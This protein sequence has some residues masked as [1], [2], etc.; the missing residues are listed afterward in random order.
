MA[1]PYPNLWVPPPPPLRDTNASADGLNTV[2]YKTQEN[3]V[4]IM[5]HASYD[6]S[7]GANNFH[8]HSGK[9][10]F[11]ALK[12]A[13]FR[14]YVYYAPHFTVYTDCNSLSYVLST[15]WLNA[16]GVRWIAE[17]TDYR[18][19]FKYRSGRKIESQTY[20]ADTLYRLPL[21]AVK[22]IRTEETSMETVH[23]IMHDA[24]AAERCPLIVHI[25]SLKTQ[26]NAELQGKKFCTEFLPNRIS[27]VS[28]SRA[29]EEDPIKVRKCVMDR[30]KPQPTEI[31]CQL[32]E[33]KILFRECRKLE[34]GENKILV[35]KP[36]R[37]FFPNCFT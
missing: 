20:T 4:K 35:R 32:P 31:Y 30:T 5:C 19:Y 18:F 12:W 17:L 33:S 16:T 21:D 1:H 15:A 7:N 10:E 29:Q 9:L 36:S 24:N 34:I 14:D 11:L 2:L 28:L 22:Q 6:V 8:L 26:P 37:L 27:P 23:A 13:H 25:S 3:I